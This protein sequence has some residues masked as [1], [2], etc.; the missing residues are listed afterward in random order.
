[1]VATPTT[2]LSPIPVGEE[3]QS[4]GLSV[5]DVFAGAGGLSLGAEWAGFRT[6][7]AVEHHKWAAATYAKNHPGAKLFQADIRDLA[8]LDGL[9]DN[10]TL[11]AGGPPCQGF[12]TSNQRT[13]SV[14]NNQNWMFEHFVRLVEV[15]RPAWV[16]FENVGGFTHTAEGVFRTTVESAFKSRGYA[17]ASGLLNAADFGVP[18][19]RQRYFLV[20]TRLKCT[21]TLPVPSGAAAPT[22]WDAI[23][24]LPILQNGSRN[25]NLPYACAAKSEYARMLRGRRR[26][27]S[28]HWVSRNSEDVVVRY[29]H[30][31][32]GRNWEAIP[33]DLMG[34][35]TDPSRCHTGIYRRLDPNQPSVVI[36]NYRKNMLIHPY[37][38]RGLSVREAAR[39]Q[40][41]PDSYEFEGS[42]G[43][44]QQQV[45]NAVPPLLARAV[46]Q[47]IA[48]THRSAISVPSVEA[49]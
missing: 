33:A 7:A 12:S 34:S 23:G 15:L 6:L 11:L 28:N 26:T 35:Y 41:F 31:G 43:F 3:A 37:Q 49:V 47:H 40:S 36:G 32:A 17:V 20:G 18:Q 27:C 22:V 46:F 38:H 24:D 48:R 14:D 2:P 44:R 13:R 1:M 16:V 45:G 29:P 21:P 8:H 39:L 5:V 9:S 19:R 30:I 10:P 25:D 4:H 42:I